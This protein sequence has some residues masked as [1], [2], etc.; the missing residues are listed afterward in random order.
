MSL[1]II[2]GKKAK[3]N[4]CQIG[5]DTKQFLLLCAARLFP[6][7][8]LCKPSFSL[9]RNENFKNIGKERCEIFYY[10]FTEF[11]P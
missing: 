11:H 7:K 10:N 6:K 1:S 3:N 8:V 5:K 4:K 2:T 9:K